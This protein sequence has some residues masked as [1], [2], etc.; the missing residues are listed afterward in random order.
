MRAEIG[1]GEGDGKRGVGGEVE[2]RVPFTP[3]SGSKGVLVIRSNW[4]R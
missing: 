4:G 3:I 1:L 2:F